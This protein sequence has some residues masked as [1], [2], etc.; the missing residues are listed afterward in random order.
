MVNLAV[1][2]NCV[3]PFLGS[4]VHLRGGKVPLGIKVPVGQPSLSNSPLREAVEI[5]TRQYN[6]RLR[7]EG[8]ISV[9]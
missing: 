7:A 6:I 4:L 5:V 8:L 3:Y 9:S 2:R 1:T